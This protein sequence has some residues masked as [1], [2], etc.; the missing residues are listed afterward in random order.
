MVAGLSHH[1]TGDR[2][3]KIS[4]SIPK[5]LIVTGDND[6]LVLPKNSLNLKKNM[7]EAEYVQWEKCAHALHVQYKKKFNALLERVFEEGKERLEAEPDKW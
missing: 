4:A 2:L 7:P 6:A 3:R 5:V 1:V